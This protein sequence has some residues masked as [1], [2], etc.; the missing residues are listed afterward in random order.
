[1]I[2]ITGLNGE[3]GSA[4]VQRLK[5]LDVKNIIG[6]DIK[7]IK[8]S[9]KSFLTK[10]YIGDIKDKHLINKIFTENKI[11][12]VYHL[13]A[14]LSTKA[15]SLPF[16]SHQINVDGFLN[17][18]YEIQNYNTKVKFFFAS[19]IAVYHL[20]KNNNVK[21]SEDEFCNPSNMYG[22]NKL[23]CE[24]IGSY[25]SKYSDLMNNLDFRSLRFSGI[26]SANTLPVG[27]TSDYAPEMIHNAV[28][29]KSYTCYVNP[30][31]CIPFMVMPDAI[32]AIITLM[33]TK[34]SSLK[35]NVYHIQAFNPTVQEIYNKLKAHFPNFQLNY[36][37]NER[38]QSLIDCWPSDLDQSAAKKDWGWEPKFNFNK[39][40]DDYLIP[41]ISDYYKMK[42]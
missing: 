26:V 15:E 37:I 32:D 28:Q 5:E 7:P 12:Q 17:L 14:I 38:R 27:G 8:K 11:E 24:R 16:L 10:S 31:S 42:E 35:R 40:F 6:L 41:Y 2:L 29:N 36:D 25:F 33:N 30:K 20:D 39:A 13:A 4:L 9:I 1:M 21:I 23:Y 34:R 22:C 19:S 3:M 18:L